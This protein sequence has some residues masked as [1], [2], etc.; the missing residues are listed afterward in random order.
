MSTVHVQQMLND[1]KKILEFLKMASREF[2]F[3]TKA[4]PDIDIVSVLISILIPVS[5]SGKNETVQIDFKLV[6]PP[7][8]GPDPEAGHHHHEQPCD[9]IFG[10]KKSPISIT[11]SKVFCH[12]LKLPQKSHI[13]WAL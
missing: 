4:K 9:Q 6:G 7:L 1:Q 11:T 10:P 2:R 8:P 12:F 3:P 13:L 5:V